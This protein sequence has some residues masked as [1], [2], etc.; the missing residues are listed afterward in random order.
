MGAFIIMLFMMTTDSTQ[1][2]C[3]TIGT[4]HLCSMWNL[5]VAINVMMALIGINGLGKKCS[6]YQHL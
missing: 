4:V 6:V 3:L 1:L 2:G 5:C